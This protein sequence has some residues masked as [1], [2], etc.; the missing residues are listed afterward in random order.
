V[1][2]I[3]QGG[4]K[5]GAHG[6]YLTALLSEWLCCKGN[7]EAVKKSLL[8]ITDVVRYSFTALAEEDVARVTET[9][10]SLCSNVADLEVFPLSGAG[11]K[12]KKKKKTDF[13][14][15]SLAK[16]LSSPCQLLDFES[17]LAVL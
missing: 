10:C 4:R 9:V 5:V 7:S 16:F 1:F 11:K 3:T 6:M 12:K 8:L 2:A 17:V 14:F 15:H 13:S